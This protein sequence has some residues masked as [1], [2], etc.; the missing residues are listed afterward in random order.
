M[1]CEACNIQFTVF[2]RKKPCM[3][4]RQVVIFV[5][6]SVASSF[7]VDSMETCRFHI[8][9]FHF[10]TDFI[11]HFQTFVLQQLFDKTKGAFSMQSMHNISHSTN[12]ENGIAEIACKRFD[13]LFAIKTYFDNRM[14]R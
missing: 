5:A 10:N 12:F 2:K 7:V 8:F 6:L 1:P 13:I 4:C 9:S 11:V 3:E 14:C